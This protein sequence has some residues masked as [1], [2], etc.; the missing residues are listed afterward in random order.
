[1]NI[2]TYAVHALNIQKLGRKGQSMLLIAG[3]LL[4]SACELIPYGPNT[5]VH[6][7]GEVT[8]IYADHET[9]NRIYKYMGGKNADV[10]G[11]RMGQTIYCKKRDFYICGHE[12]H[13][14]TDDAWHK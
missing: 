4:F 2:A 14:L 11:F 8:V 10:Q 9:I 7:I 5:E 13:H 12:L 3:V 6:F 1:M